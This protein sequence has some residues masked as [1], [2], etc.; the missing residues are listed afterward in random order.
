M[1]VSQL[2]VVTINSTINPTTDS[3]MGYVYIVADPSSA[4]FKFGFSSKNDESR[5]N[6]YKTSFYTFTKSLL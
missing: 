2:F 5:L 1:D 4:N 6:E 3:K